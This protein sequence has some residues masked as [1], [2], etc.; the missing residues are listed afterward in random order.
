MTFLCENEAAV[1]AKISKIGKTEPSLSLNH[2]L[3]LPKWQLFAIVSRT[4]QRTKFVTFQ[5]KSKQKP[6]SEHIVEVHEVLFKY[7]RKIHTCLDMSWSCNKA[8]PLDFF[9]SWAIDL[10]FCE[11]ILLFYY[12]PVLAHFVYRNP[13]DT[14]PCHVLPRHADQPLLSELTAAIGLSPFL[15]ACDL[16]KSLLDKPAVY[17]SLCNICGFFLNLRVKSGC[18][19]L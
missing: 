10:S 5:W 18:Q 17:P 12:M 13:R 11:E 15:R 14:V 2:L 8:Q 3:E 19:V 1:L 16:Q 9:I 6:I 7:F 4:A